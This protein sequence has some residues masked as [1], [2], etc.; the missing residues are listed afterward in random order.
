MLK[1]VLDGFVHSTNRSFTDRHLTV[2]GSDIGQC[3]RKVAYTKAQSKVDTN[4]HDGWGA[5]LRGTIFEN[6]VWV[7]AMQARYGADLLYAGP[8]QQ[9]MALGLLS[10]TPDG[11]LIHQP[12]DALKAFGIT[13]IGRSGEI[14]VEAKTLDPRVQ[15]DNAK[16]AHAFQVQIQLGLFHAVTKHRPDYALISYTD[17]SF[18]D[19]ITE[20][21]IKRDPAVFAHAQH[22][23]RQIMQAKTA[24][25]LKP[26]GWIAGG[27]EC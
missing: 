21:V 9:T 12:K 6:H 25:E 15:L 22:R 4:Y 5:R 13:N 3:A 1:D 14:V 2:G 27:Q 7:P 23:A 19:E 16:T 10:A 20:F 18:W 8:E 26:E 24:R 11:L 17:A